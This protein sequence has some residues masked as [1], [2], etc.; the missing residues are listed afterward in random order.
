MSA[1]DPLLSDG[2]PFVFTGFRLVNRLAS[3]EAVDQL[4]AGQPAKLQPDFEAHDETDLSPLVLDVMTY[5]NS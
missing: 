5:A 1:P 2:L 4:E 3:L